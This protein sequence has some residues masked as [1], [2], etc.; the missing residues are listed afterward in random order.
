MKAPHANLSVI[1]QLDSEVDAHDAYYVCGH[2]GSKCS[3]RRE[4]VGFQ[5]E[6]GLGWPIYFILSVLLSTLRSLQGRGQDTQK[7][8]ERD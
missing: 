7:A 5:L 6:A 4:W 8:K 3:G 1:V 2:C